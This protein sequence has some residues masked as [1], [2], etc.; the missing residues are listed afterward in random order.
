M[1]KY[2]KLKQISFK[3][4]IPLIILA[5]LIFVISAGMETKQNPQI[6]NNL[7]LS[8]FKED[9][10]VATRYTDSIEDKLNLAVSSQDNI[11][12]ENEKMKKE[13]ESLKQYINKKEENNPLKKDNLYSSFPDTNPK[14]PD[15]INTDIP[16]NFTQR[17]SP[18]LKQTKILYKVMDQTDIN[19]TPAIDPNFGKVEK[20]TDESLNTEKLYIPTTSI[21]KGALLHGLNAPTSMSKPMPTVVMIKDVAFLPNR[22]KFNI[23]ECNLLVEGYGQLSDERAYFKFTKFVCINEDGKKIYDTKASGYL[24]SLTDNK[25]GL[26]GHVVSKQDAMLGRMFLAG[27]FEGASE[28]F[29]NTGQT[30]IESPLGITT[31]QSTDTKDI[32]NNMIGGGLGTASESAKELYLE[33]A[34]NISETVEILAQEVGLV[35]TDG[36]VLEPIDFEKQKKEKE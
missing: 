22:K 30:Q 26:P 23:K 4:G 27:V 17:I 33:K 7:N 24:T 18:D 6:N 8:L 14:I 2:L 25:Q 36:L 3:I 28:M 34:R 9:E 16:N 13:I 1:D 15:L 19:K 20:K 31:S 11:K 10:L 29:K 35:F 5:V 21:S 32:A 12:S